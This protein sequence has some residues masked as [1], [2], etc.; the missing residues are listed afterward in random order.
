MFVSSKKSNM[1][2]GDDGSAKLIKISEKN[3]KD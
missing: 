3:T 2:N 1:S